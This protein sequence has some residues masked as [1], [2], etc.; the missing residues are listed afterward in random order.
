MATKTTHPADRTD[1][2]N[3]TDRADPTDTTNT[4]ETTRRRLVLVTM[5]AGYFLVLLDVTI[6]NVSLPRIASGLGAGVSDLQWVVDAYAITLAALMLTG[7]TVGDL[8]GHRRVVLTGFALFGGASLACVLA[9]TIGALVVARVA[10][11]VGAALMLPGTLAIISHAYPEPKERTAAIGVWAGIGSVALPAGPIL[12]GALTQTIGWRAIFVLNIPVVVGAWIGAARLVKETTDPGDRRLDIP[13]LVLA[14]ALLAAV[15]FAFIEAG[16]VR[17]VNGPVIAAIVAS[18]LL[19]AGL[20]AVERRHSHPMLPLALFRRRAFTIAN[21]A[22][23]VMNLCTLGLLF[24][25][26]LYLQDVHGYS[27]L[28]AGLALFPLFIPLSI[29]APLAGRLTARVGPRTPAASGLIAAAAGAALL[30]L[31]DRHT[32]Y[33]VMLPA[34]LLWGG[35]IG[36][37]VSAVVSAAVGAVDSPRA[38]LAS[39]VNNTSRQA[40]GAIGIAAFGA[41]AGSPARH[42]FLSG[43]HLAALIA[44]GLFLAAAVAVLL[45]LPRD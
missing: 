30:T 9:P 45:G 32:S 10:Q 2:A 17:G 12:G 14:A 41:L 34:L 3:T 28:T 11:G 1:T 22:A 36:V 44:A 19:A 24:V 31:L 23:G 5:C 29:V 37:L 16:H 38:G 26:S 6:V 15:T 40:G 21:G 8:Y 18:P 4:A 33:P 27:A 39:A 42:A 25:L 43:F 7:G 35:G 13:G 20:V